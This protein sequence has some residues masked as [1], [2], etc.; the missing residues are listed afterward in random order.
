MWLLVFQPEI[1]QVYLNGSIQTTGIQ[2][3]GQG[4]YSLGKDLPRKSRGSELFSIEGGK[5]AKVEEELG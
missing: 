1:L 2:E 3:R 5:L 4:G